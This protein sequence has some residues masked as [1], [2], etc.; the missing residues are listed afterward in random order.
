[1]CSVP[2][3]FSVPSTIS[4]IVLAEREGAVDGPVLALWLRSLLSHH[5][6]VGTT[7]GDFARGRVCQTQ[8]L[9]AM[10]CPDPSLI[11]VPSYQHI[12]LPALLGVLVPFSRVPQA[13]CYPG[14]EDKE[15]LP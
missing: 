5:F 8:A 9:C 10:G 15:H 3:N 2:L 11:M 14:H 6:P 1:M 13:S 4:G 7:K 12:H